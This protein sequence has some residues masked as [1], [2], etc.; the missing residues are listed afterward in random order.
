MRKQPDYRYLVLGLFASI[1][2]IA[3]TGK[4]DVLGIMGIV[5][6]AVILARTAYLVAGRRRQ[7][8]VAVALGG[9]A[10]LPVAWFRVCP[11][12]FSLDVAKAIFTL[13]ILFWILFTLTTGLIV[14][15]GIL[16]AFRIRA[17]EIYGA[18]F[19]YLL[20]GVLFAQAYQ[21]LITFELCAL[22]F[23]PERFGTPQTLGSG[24]SVRSVGDIV[25][26]SFVTLGTVGYGDVTPATPLARA[27]SMTEE[28]IGVMYVATMIA[29]FVS[30]ETSGRSG[31]EE[32]A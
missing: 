22:Y 4:L 13:D 8:L 24:L 10:L 27:V 2:V 28:I 25:Y 29:R 18:I 11:G 30:I 3:A 21:L 14:F 6:S 20:I 9:F 12:A 15:R 5:A 17:N 7:V 23:E 16:T 26:F 32:T 31:D 19:V 1:F